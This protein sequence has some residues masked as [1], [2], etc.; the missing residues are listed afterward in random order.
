MRSIISLSEVQYNSLSGE[1]NWG[2]LPYGVRLSE[3]FLFFGGL[4]TEKL[5]AYKNK[6]VQKAGLKL[7]FN[8]AF[9]LWVEK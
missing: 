2:A 9:L 3:A 7:R 5:L 4:R 6:D 1:Y 8:P